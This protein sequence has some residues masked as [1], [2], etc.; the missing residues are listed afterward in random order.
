[1][2]YRDWGERSTRWAGIRS[3]TVD[4]AGTSVHMLTADAS[5]DVPPEAP[6]QLLVHP[7]ANGATMWLDVIRPLTAYGPVIAP[8]LPGALFGHTESP[9][10]AAPRAEPSARFLRALISTLRLGPAVVHGWSMGG[11]VA[12]R[13]AH[14]APQHVERLVLMNPTLPGPLTMAERFGWQTLGRLA[15]SAGP[16]MA[17]GTVRFW[18][19]RTIE[20]KLRY[21]TDP[22]KL[23]T[24]A[25][26]YSG[27]DP[28]RLAPENPMLWADQLRELQSRPEKMAAAATAFASVVSAMFIDRR[29]ALE[30]IDGV[31]V[32]VLLLWGEHDPLITRP[33]IDYVTGR[34]PD[35]ALHVLQTAGHIA[36][37]ELPQAYADAVGL[38][39]AR[40]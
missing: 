39:L 4:V 9:H 22:E 33:V 18:G 35:W 6:A 30:A 1:M 29:P 17:R 2:R 27:G 26:E 3:T 5:A 25:A 10:W 20:A 32:P 19:S 36:P 11:H 23:S 21:V 14:L 7:M 16:A 12:L 13:F 8:D 34:R 15:D 28:S 37:L 31:D 38:W 24:S 40:G